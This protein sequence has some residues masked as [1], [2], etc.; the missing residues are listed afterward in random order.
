MSQAKGGA[1]HTGAHSEQAVRPPPPQR[2]DLAAGRGGREAACPQSCGAAPT[3]LP[4]KWGARPAG[5]SGRRHF[6]GAEA[7]GL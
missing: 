7:L 3:V 1:G 5:S 2:W 4:W 6:C